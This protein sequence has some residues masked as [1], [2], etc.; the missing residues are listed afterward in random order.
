MRDA[1]GQAC[2]RR[3]DDPVRLAPV[4][5]PSIMA[6]SGFLARSLLSRRKCPAYSP[7]P[8]W[9]FIEAWLPSQNGL[10]DEAPQRH[11]AWRLRIS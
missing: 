7:S 6:T 8:S 11:R 3:F 5:G 4:K 2:P 10:F 9:N 1:S